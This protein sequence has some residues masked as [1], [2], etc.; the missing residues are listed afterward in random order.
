MP[1][2]L[3][4]NLLFLFLDFCRNQFLY[5]NSCFLPVVSV[6]WLV[7]ELATLHHRDA[8]EK[9]Q[10]RHGNRRKNEPVEAP[11]GCIHQPDSPPHLDLAEVI[12]M[13]AILPQTD[14]ANLTRM[15][16]TVANEYNTV[17]I[18]RLTALE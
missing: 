3:S 6:S 16:T 2:L 4:Q 11:K 7:L 14:I 12:G 15:T 13:A 10:G 8:D 1:H 5:Q 18:T 17:M 9:E